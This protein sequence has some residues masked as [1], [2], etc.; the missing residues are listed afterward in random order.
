MEQ[1]K[2]ADGWPDRPLSEDEAADRLGENGRAVWVMDAD[3]A[4]RSATVPP[5]APDDPV[6]DLVVETDEAFEMYSYSRGRWM[7]YG[8]Q[9]KDD[10]EAP[11]MAGTLASYRVLVGESDLDL[12]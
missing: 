11:S 9:R 8:T 4:V 5:D 7:D 3:S 6:I 10:D 2:P 12:D 1:P